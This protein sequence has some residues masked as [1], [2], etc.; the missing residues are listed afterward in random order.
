MQTN[1][2]T[3]YGIHDGNERNFFISY[4]IFIAVS[5]LFGDSIILVASLKYQAIRLH[6]IIVIIIQH[7]AL[8]DLLLTLFRIVPQTAALIADNWVT[9]AFFG[10]VQ[11]SINLVFG[12]LTMCLT[13]ALTTV[14][15]LIVKYPLRTGAW[16]SRTGHV[17]CTALWLWQLA[18]WIPWLVVNMFYVRETLFFSYRT[19]QCSYDNFSPNTPEWFRLYASVNF[20]VGSVLLMVLI[21]VII[22][23]SY[24]ISFLH[25][26]FTFCCAYRMPN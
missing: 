22:I 11:N 23:P 13:C 12:G 5:S 19:Y 15:L 6:K 25:I 14:K 1:N 20:L 7:L 18:S 24:L 26:S 17:I 2:R 3:A 8:C 10:H 4:N 9:G 16:S 21:I